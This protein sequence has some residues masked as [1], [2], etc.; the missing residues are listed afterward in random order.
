MNFNQKRYVMLFHYF[1]PGIVGK[2][3]F[4]VPKYLGA[5]LNTDTRFVYP[6]ADINKDFPSIYRGVNL[7]PIKSSSK[8]YATIWSEKEM[9][10]WLI[11]HARE[12]D[13]LQLF[14]LSSRNLIF[15]W[16]YKKL[17][18]KGIVYIKGDLNTV[19]RFTKGLKGLVKS[20]LYKNLDILSVET[21][22]IYDKIKEG[23]S[24][25]YLKKITR[26]MPNG[27]DSELRESLHIK[28]KGY[29]EKENLIIT[30]G[31]IGTK[32]KNNEMLLE[33]IS[34]CELKGWKVALIGPIE[35]DFKSYIENF[36]K[37]FSHLSD[38]VIFT[39]AVYDKSHLWEWYNRA[40]VFCLTSPSECMAQVYSE[41]LTFGNYIITTPVV[42]SKEI[43]DNE[44]L[45]CYVDFNSPDSL[46]KKIQEIIDD[47]SI[48]KYTIPEAFKLSDERFNWDVLV[49]PIVQEIET[50]LK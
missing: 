6:I 1:G 17:N 50:L 8:Y 21:K 43:T 41:A 39:E 42:G 45:G 20:R 9:A 10:W 12:I 13:I 48:L 5:K 24:G 37:K 14:W 16:I 15:A 49:N 23:Y 29:H 2:D 18:S 31:R 40:K 25:E 22:E 36:Y 7:V 35:E 4:L 19:P 34:K 26:W 38:S 27:F 11:K 46:S 30:V 3:M 28:R 47:D 33:A 44:R 32:E